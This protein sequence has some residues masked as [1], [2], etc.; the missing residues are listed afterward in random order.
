MAFS[1]ADLFASS[2]CSIVTALKPRNYS[3][4][5]VIPTFKYAAN[6]IGNGNNIIRCSF[7]QPR[8]RP[9]YIPNR[10]PDASYV[11]VLDTTLRDGEQAPGA[12]MTRPEKL[13]IA[14][15]LLEL[16]V[17][18]IDAGFPASSKEELE[19]TKLIAQEIG[20]NNNN[21]NNVSD[22]YCCGYV[23]VISAC[24][25]CIRS[26]IDAAWD[27]VKPAKLRR[28]NVFI[29]TSEIHMKYKLNKTPEQ[30]LKLAKESVSHAKSLG[31]D[32]IEFLCEDAGRSDK[33]FLYR[34][35]GEAIKAGATTITFAD[36][37]GY[38]FPT[39]V[40]KIMADLKANIEGIENVIISA[41]CHND[42][43]LANANSLAAVCA[44]ARQVEVTINGIG[45]RA[46]NASLEEF[47]MAIK[48][49][50]DLLG[51][52]YTGINTKQ[53][54]PASKMVE[55]YSG[56]SL[57]PHKAIVGANIFSH[58]SGIHQDGILKNKSTYEIISPED[59]GLSRTNE[60]RIVLGKHSGRH[61]LNSRLL[62]LGYNLDK[63]QLDEAFGNFKAVAETKKFLTDKDIESLVSKL[64]TIRN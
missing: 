51:G 34:V 64:S 31:C 9:E 59:I 10:I 1:S 4:C 12:A 23:P 33:E 27:A 2:T 48:S 6:K 5:G 13:A 30:V 47:V 61:A 43:G 54:V 26:D 15:K 49:R 36:T 7:S 38:N 60:S 28:L 11:R 57:Q 40:E 19:T 46:G 42:L 39:E 58:A 25:R 16:R 29:S 62:E 37:V 41:H 8:R 17:D 55:E 35:Y 45:E 21:N 20:N 24:A 18:V 56:L 3:G 50:N 14:R 53:I 32:D 63:T 22:E 52:L 44:G